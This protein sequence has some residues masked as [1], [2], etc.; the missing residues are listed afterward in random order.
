MRPLLLGT[1]F[2][3]LIAFV[4]HLVAWELIPWH[5]KTML[6]FDREDEVVAAIATHAPRDGTYILAKPGA[7]MLA[8]I[9]HGVPSFASFMIIQVLYLMAASFLLTWLMLQTS[10]LTYTRRVAFAAVVGLAASV[11]IDLPNWN[12]FG[13]SGAYTAVNLADS[14]I[15]WA[16]AGLAIAK[17]TR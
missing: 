8:G 4:W 5:E 13:F 12:W 2:G 10:G 14:T 3:T 16:L 7:A 17:V 6:T 1:I 11:M 15:T 9:R